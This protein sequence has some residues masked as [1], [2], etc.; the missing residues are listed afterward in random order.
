MK[1]ACFNVAIIITSGAVVGFFTV[2]GYFT[3]AAYFNGYA[4]GFNDARGRIARVLKLV[5]D[6]KLTRTLLSEFDSGTD[7]AP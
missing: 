6:R 2:L 1:N 3:R 7:G 5:N 4:S